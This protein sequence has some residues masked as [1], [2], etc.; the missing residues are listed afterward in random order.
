MIIDTATG[1]E[2]AKKPANEGTP[3]KPEM[4]QKT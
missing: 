4:E 2:G 3:G 1:A